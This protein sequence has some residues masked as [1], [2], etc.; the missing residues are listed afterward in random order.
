MSCVQQEITPFEKNEFLK[1]KSVISVFKLYD[2]DVK[3]FSN[4]PMTW[5]TT[6]LDGLSKENDIFDDI[7]CYDNLIS[8]KPDKKSYDSVYKN[9]KKILFVD[10]CEEN[11]FKLMNDPIWIP[12]LYQKSHIR[13]NTIYN[14][15]TLIEYI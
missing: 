10:D 7:V 1:W 14:P 4:A 6:C 9:E 8:L 2:Y 13:Y 5:I 3:I 11:L 15:E 12:I